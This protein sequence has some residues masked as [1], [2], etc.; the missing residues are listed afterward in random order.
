MPP[1]LTPLKMLDL[2]RQLPG[3]FCSTLL[4]DL[5]MDVLTVGAPNDPMGAG[6]PFLGR[7]KRSLT[8]NLKDPRGRA[9][10][11]RLAA[12][13]D[14]VLEGARP[15][16]AARLGVDYPTLA[17]LNPRI[18]YC[19]LSG[20]GQDGPYRDRVGHDINYLGFAGVLEFIG[21]A[22]G[23]PIVPGV[24]IA[25]IGGGALMAA[26]GILAA[27]IARA[28]TGRGQLVDI[29]ML[30][31]S[32]AWNVYHM[33]LQQ[34][35]GA[36]PK[37]GGEQLTGQNACYNVYETRDGRYVTV[38]AYEAHFWATLCRHFGREDFVADQWATGERRAEILAFFR[39]A[40]REKTMDQWVAELASK[41][42]CFGPVNTLDDAFAD[43]QLRSRGM[44]LDVDTPVGRMRAPA[45]PVRLSDTPGGM[46]TAPVPYGTHTDTVL[47][48]LGMAADE[49]ARLRADGVV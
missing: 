35:A 8:L 15:G 5:G 31:G 39:A 43:P 25:D 18:I 19:S 4:A 28:T 40:F 11:H 16:V 44:V 9:I 1:A 29:A 33:L 22:G 23:A 42:I 47:A 3:P 37:R 26:V 48:G 10:F 24:Q 49:I 12:D 46:R 30:D 14:V 13:A 27:V 38:G 20:Y 34:L 7:N 6:I 32:F 2:S 21:P 45:V 41:E 17:A 36:P